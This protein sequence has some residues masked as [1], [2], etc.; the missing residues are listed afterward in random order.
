[1][2]EKYI[3]RHILKAF[4]ENKKVYNAILVTGSRQ[5][6]KTTF[7]IEK[8]K[9]VK[10][11]SLD[12]LNALLSI[13]NDPI[14]FFEENEK[15]LILDEIQRSKES[16]V[17]IKY[18]IDTYRKTKKIL[19]ILTGS[20]KYSLM[21]NISES[22]AGRI[23][24][25]EM[26]GLSNRELYKYDFKVP[27]LP[28]KNYFK[29]CKPTYEFTKKILWKRILAGSY[30]AI[31]S[32]KIKDLDK[33][34]NNLVESYVERDVREL[35]NV[36]DL[37][38]FKQFLVLVAS[39]SGQLLNMAEI[40]KEISV[41]SKTVKNWI[42]ILEASNIIY[43]L[44]PFSLN[45]NKRIIK[46]PKLYFLDTGL[47]CYLTNWKTPE[48][49]ESGASAGHIYETFVVSEIIKSYANAG[50]KCDMYYF[51]STNQDEIDLLFYYNNTLY[52]IEIKKTATP[53][54][55]DI[56]AFKLLPKYYKN[57]KIGTGGIICNAKELIPLSQNN[58]II[59]INYV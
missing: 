34:Y 53:N 31:Y 2:S 41:D 3:E 19:Y 44:Y 58:Y 40:A 47:L 26:Y 25:L 54:I 57:V 30:P 14:G 28:D 48:T 39:R 43:L 50:K 12:N 35:I 5:V 10:Y 33:Y 11:I 24:I 22:L 18:M 17:T 55:K 42:S 45:I 15:V 49:L 52:P 16:F 6:G 29:K 59:P 36:K 1:M 20:Q 8:S 32:R 56:S 46:T 38:A 9:N 7:L 13:K 21:K 37:M 4:N 51:R 23:A 27:F